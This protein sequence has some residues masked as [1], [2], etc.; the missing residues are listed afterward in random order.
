MH[1]S[2]TMKNVL[3]FL[4]VLSSCHVLANRSTYE[5]LAEVNK[6]WQEQYDIN[7]ALLPAYG[8]RSE[9]EWIRLHLSMVETCLRKRKYRDMTAVQLQNRAH[10]LDIL[11][12]YW[13]E[14][15]FPKNENYTF[16]TPI[17]IDPYD[18]FCAVGF[19]LKETGY[20][21]V[22]RKVAT[23]MNLAYVHQ[24]PYPELSE[25]AH[26]YGF[27]TDELAWIQPGYPSSGSCGQVGQGVKGI[28]KA[29][30]ADDPENKLYVGGH[31]DTAHTDL[32]ANNIAYVS[33]TM[34]G[35]FEWHT[36]GSGVEGEV[37]SICKFGTD[38]FLGGSISSAGGN[39]A[40]NV[41]YWDGTE[42]HEAGCLDGV[43]YK[44]ATFDGQLYAA[45][46]FRSCG[47]DTG[48]HFAVW[49]GTVWS[50]IGGVDGRINTIEVFGKELVL[51]GAFTFAGNPANAI[52]WDPHSGFQLFGNSILHEVNDFEF[53]KDTLYVACTHTASTDTNL[54]FLK[55]KDNFWENAIRDSSFTSIYRSHYA[56]SPVSFR[57]LCK[58]TGVLYTGGTFLMNRGVTWYQNCF[59]LAGRSRL[60]LPGISGAVNTSVMF[61]DKLFF[62]GN[63]TKGTVATGPESAIDINVKSICYRI[64][65]P[66][67][68]QEKQ[69]AL[70]IQK[71][72]PNPVKTGTP[73]NIAGN[74]QGSTYTL[75]SSDG[76]NCYEGEIGS[77][78]TL[79]VPVVSPGN[80]LLEIRDRKGRKHNGKITIQ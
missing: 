54:L 18:N 28:V 60:D 49:D 36:M 73:L 52:R 71:L 24:I 35:I 19:L 64:P 29:L 13:E 67:S 39:P 63:F 2:Y 33:E 17:F 11:H 30:L 23:N 3:I 34:A 15:N 47:T 79:Q 7:T 31:F 16:R 58:D 48:M 27:T 76:K 42:W 55:L 41:C 50:M 9:K 77:Q 32:R 5:K 8:E 53:F 40:R 65:W 12:R 74:F 62:G 44:L 75:Y 6:C 1:K 69:A 10:C 57:T 21:A 22:S 43:V 56:G 66:V 61:N 78:Q 51:G 70:G 26:E 46:E 72:Y 45:G 80:Y 37:N 25:W 20:E 4:L 59:L 38:I 14:G 68:V